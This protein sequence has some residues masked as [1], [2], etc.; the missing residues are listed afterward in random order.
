MPEV[1]I[2]KSTPYIASRIRDAI[3]L[4]DVN[5]KDVAKAIKM[6]E[7]SFS[8]IVNANQNPGLDTVEKIAE[9]LDMPMDFF[10]PPYSLNGA[11][12]PQSKLRASIIDDIMVFSTEYLKVLKVVTDAMRVRLMGKPK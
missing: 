7:S 5:Q 3:Q 6:S 2:R 9:A 1:S 12:N 10:F 8:N 4:A 11:K